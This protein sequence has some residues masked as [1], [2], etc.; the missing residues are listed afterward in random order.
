MKIVETF[1]PPNDLKTPVLFLVF[2]RPETTSIV[3][4]TIRRAKPPKLYIASDGPRENKENEENLVQDVRK[5]VQN[6]DWLCEVHTLFRTKNLGCKLAVSSAITWFFDKEDKGI[7][8]ED[9]CLPS[10]SFFW[11]CE[12][13]LNRFLNDEQVFLI[14]GDGRVSSKIKIASDIAYCKYPMI[15][16]WASWSRVWKKY[17]VY[18]T[19]WPNIKHKI[20]EKHNKNYNKLFWLNTFE[21]LYDNKI[22]TWDYQLAFLLQENEAFCIIPKYN[23]VSNIGFGEGATH[24]FDKNSINA[25]V[26]SNEIELPINLNIIKSNNIKINNYFDENEFYYPTWLFR[27]KKKLISIFFNLYI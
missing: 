11:Y 13:M 20:I 5:I 3:F 25:N 23:L 12:F 1:I 24:T 15:W 21:L 16:G 2:N 27:V 22:N 4:E 14:S 6:I 19:N 9:D 7:I 10:L 18:I 8:L 26:L 17:D